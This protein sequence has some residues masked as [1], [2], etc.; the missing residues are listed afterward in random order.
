MTKIK[1][2]KRNEG[3]EKSPPPAPKNA[4]PKKKRS[5]ESTVQD[6]IAERRENDAD[7]T[8]DRNSQLDSWSED[9]HNPTEA[10]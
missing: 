10:V 5:M 7:E 4:K 2:I 6:W 8:R 3:G 1:V 9:F